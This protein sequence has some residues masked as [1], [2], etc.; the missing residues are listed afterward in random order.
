M[1]IVKGALVL[2]KAEK[3]GANLFVLKG[4]TLHEA[5]MWVTSNREELA[6]LWH[7]KL[8]HMSEQGLKIISERILLPRLKSVNLPFCEHCVTSKQHRLKF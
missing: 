3:I 6:M 1:K 2:I 7:L 5:D 4:E 8:S